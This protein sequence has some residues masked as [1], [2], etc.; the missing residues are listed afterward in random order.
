VVIEWA[1]DSSVYGLAWLVNSSVNVPPAAAAAAAAPTSIGT[2]I[3]VYVSLLPAFG[4]RDLEDDTF[5]H[6]RIQLREKLMFGHMLGTCWQKKKRKIIN[7]HLI[8][9]PESHP[10][11][12][13]IP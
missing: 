3:D 7:R 8:A 13:G 4:M 5:E 1:S 10:A 2:Q 9:Y 6:F 12:Y 11:Q